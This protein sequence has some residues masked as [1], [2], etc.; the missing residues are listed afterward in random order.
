MRNIIHKLLLFITLG[1][2]ITSCDDRELAT[3]NTDA[4]SN[5]TLSQSSLIL[6]Q[7]ND[8]EN[9]LTTNWTEPDFGFNAS[10]SYK[11]LIDLETGDFS[12][13]QTVV[14]DN[15]FEKVFT[16]EELNSKLLGLDADPNTATNFKF[17]IETKLSDYKKLLSDPVSII[18]TAYP[19]ILDLS[20]TWGVV[21]SATPNG[22]NGPDLP[23]FQTGEA[24]I[25]AAYV[26]LNG[27]LIKFRENN[28]WTLNYGDDGV[29]GTLEQDGA[30]IPVSAGS[31]KIVINLND[32][33]YT[34]TPFSW[35]I[36]GSA[37]PNGWNGPDIELKYDEYSNTFRA[38]AILTDGDIKFRMNNAWDF[39]YGDTDADGTLESEN[40]ANITVTAGIYLVTLNLTDPDNPFYTMEDSKLWGI[41]GDATPNGWNGPDV[42]FRRDFSSNDEIWV[43]D[44]IT[45]TN[46]SIKFRNNDSWDLSYGDNDNDGTLESDNG[47]NI[48]VTAGTYKIVLDFS[49]QANP[50]YTKTLL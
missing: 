34:I 24:N 16:K 14:L 35:G 26:T 50:T 46:G 4:N 15:S 10:A 44:S 33:T 48:P 32:L 43:I 21:G 2:L 12:N 17:V 38:I 20:T 19:S 31:Y 49:D 18:L 41:V 36:V 23:F 29:D 40:G 37:T 42:K 7:F 3:L 30:N 8:G 27:G 45:L 22:W 25:Y 9:V 13:P 6:A 47:A 11:L 5:L 28:S 39:S 1:V